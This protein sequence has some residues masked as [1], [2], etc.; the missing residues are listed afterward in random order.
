LVREMTRVKFIHRAVRTIS[1]VRV[2]GLLLG[3]VLLSVASAE[4][5][6]YRLA[7]DRNVDNVTTGYR[8]YYGTASGAYQPAGGID[9]G[10]VVEFTLDL[11]PGQTYFFLVRAQSSS[12]SLGPPST[13]LRFTVPLGASVAVNTASVSPGATVTATITDGPGNRSD[14]VGFFPSGAPSTGSTDWRYLNGT[15][16]APATG[17][18]GGTVS[19]VVPNAPGTYEVRFYTDAHAMLASSIPITV[20]GSAS[21]TVPSVTV[22][23]SLAVG[24]NFTVAVANGPA[25][26]YDWVGFYPSSATGAGGAISWK[27]LNGLQVVPATGVS[28]ANLTFV[29]PTQAGQYRV[30]FLHNSGSTSTVLA[31]SGIITVSSSATPPASTSGAPTVTPSSVSVAAGGSITARIANGPGGRLDWVGLFPVGA[32]NTTSNIQW[33]YLNG[34]HTAPATGSSSANVQ[35]VAPTQ[36]G[37]YN[38]R[39][40]A[41]GGYTVLATSAVITVSATAP[42][43]PPPTGSPTVTPS[44]TSVLPG[45]SVTARVTNGP[46]GRLDWVGLYASGAG[47]SAYVDWFYLNG[48]KVAPSTG[49][50]TANVVFRM[51]TTAGQYRIRL[52]ANNDYVLLSTSGAITVSST[53]TPT[54]TPSVTPSATTVA[55]GSLINVS[56]A[57]GPGTRLDWVGIYLSGKS[58]GNF[59][60]WAYLNGSRVAPSAGLSNT[61]FSLRVPSTPGTYVLRFYAN[62]VYTWLANS[63]NIVVQ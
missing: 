47:N 44:V 12:S 24:Q 21:A 28:S 61:T 60:D 31:T 7:W 16:T 53:T 13:E 15:R 33:F 50:A 62:N 27:Y 52:F 54:T 29:A 45:G 25:S 56:I 37:Q 57:N 14:W 20:V 41:H 9:V 4:A 55:R 30:R 32:S 39:F 26:R 8:V 59:A 38:L 6:P 10:N 3:L 49:V 1:R 22:P 63:V 11:T 48:S 36:A 18:T 42:T 51:P 58:D 43:T 19:F 40:F 34:S 35:F 2:F 5:R 46:A 17:M 23:L